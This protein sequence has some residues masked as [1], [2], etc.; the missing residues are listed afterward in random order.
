MSPVKQY[1]PSFRIVLDGTELRHGVTVDVLSVSVVDNADRADSFNFTVR[2]HHPEPGRLFA[3]GEKL[4][5]MDSD[6]FD[7]GNKVEIHMGYV[8]DLEPMLSGEITAVSPSFPANGQPTLRVEGYSL[9]HRLQRT[10]LRK[11]FKSITDSNI[12]REIATQMNLN[13]KVDETEVEY[14]LVSPK[15]E[16]SASFLRQRAERI[17]YE[18]VVKQG[19]LSFQQPR[20]LENPGPGL[21]LEWGTSLISF[22]PRLSTF[23]APT[24]V[25]VR[26]SQTS[27]GRGKEALVGTARVGDERVKMGTETGQ[28]IAQRAFGDHHLLVE[29]HSITS[30][31]EANEVARARLETQAM[32]FVTGSGSCIGNPQLKARMVIELKGLGKR[33][34]GNYYVTTA[35]HTIDSG[36]YRTNFQVKRNAR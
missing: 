2:D 11:P 24:E 19:T 22:S 29:D 17:G 9:Y 5:W 4:Q 21:T 33:F 23:N 30:S 26:G 14:P 35:T 3:G 31:Q 27:Q 32:D 13:P 15:G 36:G 8:D 16:T 1:A 12:V 28:Q 20:Y 6:A 18:V 34:S 25:T 10:R 7:E